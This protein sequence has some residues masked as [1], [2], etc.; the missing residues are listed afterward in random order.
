MA[1]SQVLDKGYR[2]SHRNIWDSAETAAQIFARIRPY[3]PA[4]KQAF[5]Y[6]GDAEEWVCVGLNE[7]LRTLRYGAGEY[8]LPHYDGMYVRADGLAQS[9]LTVRA[10]ICR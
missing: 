9:Y 5:G 10:T 7:R 3:L 6:D 4:G 1:D 2:N 8:F